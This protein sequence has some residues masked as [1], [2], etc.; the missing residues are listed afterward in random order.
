MRAVV[1]D[2]P[3]DID[4][5]D[6]PDPAPGP[7]DVVVA[8]HAC[9]I[10]GT[11]LHVVDG[12]F[13]LAKYPV[14]PGHEFAGE[15]VEVGKHVK[16]VGVGAM[17]TADPN[18]PCGR[19]RPCREGHENL[20]EEFRAMG[21]TIPGACA[22]YVAVPYWLARP[23]PQGFDMSVGALV[24]PLSCVVHGY[25]LIRTRLGD[26]FL[27]Y[28]AGTMGLMLVALAQRVG[29]VSVTVVEPHHQRRQLARSFGAS[30]V[31]ASSVELGDERFNIVI[32]ASGV[33]PVVEDALG[34]VQR[35][36]TYLQF[37]VAPA[38]AK[39]Q[40]SPY[41]LYNDETSY[42]GSMA[43]LHSFDRAR[44]LAVEL[45]LGLSRLVTDTLPLG[46]Y[47]KALEQVRAGSGLKVQVAPKEA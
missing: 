22:E 18:Q 44:D 7:G 6:V 33:V 20:C 15:V 14:V 42:V 8:V 23:L 39:A 2:K 16:G 34:H 36:G 38:D 3:G 19:C 17:V 25:D 37:G 11:D 32:D 26:H 27:I 30:T 40:F 31:V 1:I 29:A 9:G 21:I 28:G 47:A 24:E 12:E 45:D 5:G 43:V 10:C 4:V 35:G 46:S 13:S 41:R